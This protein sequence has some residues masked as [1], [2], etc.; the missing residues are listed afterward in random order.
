VLS[1]KDAFKIPH[2]AAGRQISQ[3]LQA[4]VFKKEI[5]IRWMDS[6]D[7]LH[8]ERTA[9]NVV[10]VSMSRENNPHVP[11]SIA[12]SGQCRGQELSVVILAGVDECESVAFDHSIAV[13]VRAPRII[14]DGQREDP[15]DDGLPLIS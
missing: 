9:S 12:Q 8:E 11:R 6:L 5:K 7:R 13:V 10:M 3:K 15:I 2:R 1:Q 14:P 4:Q